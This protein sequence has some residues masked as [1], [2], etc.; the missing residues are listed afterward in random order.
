MQNEYYEDTIQFNA[1][2]AKCILENF[3]TNHQFLLTRKTWK[4]RT[5]KARRYATS[6]HPNL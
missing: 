1:S 2:I 4:H 5:I 6:Q 3:I